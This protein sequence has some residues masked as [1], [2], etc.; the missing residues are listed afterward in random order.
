[1]T[2]GIDNSSMANLATKP[3]KPQEFDIDMIGASTYYRVG[4]LPDRDPF[5]WFEWRPIG[6]EY[7]YPWVTILWG[8]YRIAQPAP[9]PPQLCD[10]YDAPPDNGPPEKKPRLFKAAPPHKCF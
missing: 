1:M 3:E 6:I 2:F 9:C 4:Y 8:M 10:I 5:P 7:L